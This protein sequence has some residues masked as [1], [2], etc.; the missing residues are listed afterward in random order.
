MKDAHELTA[1]YFDDIYPHDQYRREAVE[2]RE[3]VESQFTD[4]KRIRVLDL[5]TGT[6]RVLGLFSEEPR[7]DLTGI[8]VSERMVARAQVNYPHAAFLRHDV[9][10]LTNAH[11]NSGTFHCILMASA[12]IQM[13]GPED[14][15]MIFDGVRDL[16]SEDGVLILDVLPWEPE[17]EIFEGSAFLKKTFR[18]DDRQVVVLYHRMPVPP[19]GPSKQFVHMVE[20]RPNTVPVLSSGVVNLFDVSI[21]EVCIELGEACLLPRTLPT[22]RKTT[23]FLIAG[24]K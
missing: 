3:V 6:G 24:K 22:A 20:C 15:R 5:C 11:F 10:N 1:E 19:P 18:K 12:S 16:L 23:Q 8:D 21:E 13:F 17:K 4:D 2:I 9:R 14:R 7:F